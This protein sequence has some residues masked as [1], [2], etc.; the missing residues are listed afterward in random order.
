[1]TENELYHHGVLGMKWGV[2]R[3]QNKDGSLT[4]AGQKRY[5]RR[6]AKSYSFSSGKDQDKLS[7]E[8]LDTKHTKEFILNNQNLKVL[9]EANRKV[10]D[11]LFDGKFMPKMVHLQ[12]ES[13][14]KTMNSFSSEDQKKIDDMFKHETFYRPET[15]PL[16][17]AYKK[18]LKKNQDANGYTKYKEYQNKTYEAYFAAKKAYEKDVDAYVSDFLGTYADAP[19]KATFKRY[20][21]TGRDAMNEALKAYIRYENYRIEN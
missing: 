2:R 10:N 3:Y 12:N 18:E 16:Y 8:I 19:V 1:M 13:L 4:E 9:Q 7:K 5:S 21:A 17:D 11:M 14:K 6:I 15:K 20:G